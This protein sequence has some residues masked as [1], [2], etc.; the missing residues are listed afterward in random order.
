MATE[1]LPLQNGDGISCRIVDSCISGPTSNKRIYS[2]IIGLW[3]SRNWFWNGDNLAC[4][5]PRSLKSLTATQPWCLQPVIYLPGLFFTR[6]GGLESS[7]IDIIVSSRRERRTPTK[8]VS[9]IEVKSIFERYSKSLSRLD[10]CYS[11]REKEK[12]PRRS[13][14]CRCRNGAGGL[15]EKVL[16]N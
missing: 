8:P 7:D 11:G 1:T 9:T 14:Y 3:C 4:L 15:R 10:S 12:N 13:S 16:K 2:G 6:E 5:W